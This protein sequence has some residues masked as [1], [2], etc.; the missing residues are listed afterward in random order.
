MTT[1]RKQVEALAVARDEA[2]L[3]ESQ[4]TEAYAVWLMERGA[5]LNTAKLKA[6]ERVA[7]LEA[8][9]RAAALAEYEAT[10]EKRPCPGIEIKMNRVV[11]YDPGKALTWAIEHSMALI[12]VQL[13]E[14]IYRSLVLEGHALGVVIEE[15]VATIG[16]DL[17]RALKE[18]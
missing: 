11:G 16:R 9:V 4:V 10:K 13:D 3:A 5:A 1:L 12:P 6:K 18:D 17:H 8:E 15:P 2:V 7:A 14:R